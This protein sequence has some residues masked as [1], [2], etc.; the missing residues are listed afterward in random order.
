M[1]TSA[2]RIS[3]WSIILATLTISTGRG[4]EPVNPPDALHGIETIYNEDVHASYYI[5][6]FEIWPQPEVMF[7]P[8]LAVSDAGLR[9]LILRM[10]L[11]GSMRHAMKSFSVSIDSDPVALQFDKPP[12]VTVDPSGCWSVTRVNLGERNALIRSIG[13]ARE[14]VV[15]YGRRQRERYELQVEDLARFRQIIALADMQK[16]PPVRSEAEEKKFEDD[17]AAKGITPPTIIRSSKVFPR[18]PRKARETRRKFS[19]SVVLGAVVR[20]DG[21][22]GDIRVTRPAGG[23]CGFEEAAIEAVKQWRYEPATKDGHPVAIYFTVV[24]DFYYE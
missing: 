4:A 9:I 22:V 21:T 8:V 5:P 14:V 16:L 24:V 3:I 10:D 15:T 6:R 19:G 18:Y 7:Y 23:Y 11:K 17:L 20:E 2:A 1:L 13:G 12:T